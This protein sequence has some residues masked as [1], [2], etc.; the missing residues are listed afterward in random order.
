MSTSIGH[1]KIMNYVSHQQLSN[2]KS[3]VLVFMPTQQS[4]DFHH[5]LF[6]S[7]LSEGE[8]NDLNLFKLHG[9]MPQKDRTQ[10]FQKFSKLK[11]G[12]LLCTVSPIHIKDVV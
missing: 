10:I 7:V 5:D 8:D 1:S 12:L 9:E 6:Q 2:K 4:V 3:K 11:D